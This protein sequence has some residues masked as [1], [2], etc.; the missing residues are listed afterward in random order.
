M[1]NLE[2]MLVSRMKEANLDLEK[3]REIE[4]Q[5]VLE[6]QFS[7]EEFLGVREKK[8]DGMKSSP[9]VESVKKDKKEANLDL[10]VSNLQFSLSPNCSITMKEMFYI[11][12]RRK[13]GSISRE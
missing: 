12:D 1:D 6:E 13:T 2:A 11:C 3:D 8:K 7:L 5:K 4:A 9:S 10:E